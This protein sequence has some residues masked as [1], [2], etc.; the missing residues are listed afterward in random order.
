MP[1]ATTRRPSGDSRGL[2][3]WSAF[4]P[5]GGRRALAI[6]PDERARCLR[7]PCRRATRRARWRSRP[8][9]RRP[10]T[11]PTESTSGTGVPAT[12]QA[13]RRRTSPPKSCPRARTAA[14]RWPPASATRLRSAD[15]ASRSP[16]RRLRCSRGW[17]AGGSA[18]APPSTPGRNSASRNCPISSLAAMIVCTAPPL[19]GTRE[20]PGRASTIVPSSPQSPRAMDRRV[21]E[22]D[23][24]AALDRHP[25]ELAVGEEADRPA[26]RREER[27]ACRPRC[28]GSARRSDRPSRRR[29]RPGPVPPTT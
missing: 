24:C 20:R 23:R 14:R 13:R 4:G 29:S 17:A 28:R 27:P 5:G 8:R 11:T 6:E 16:A 9:R 2:R 12:R 18:P 21:G 10:R 26:V 15:G 25:L 22:H 19:A 7:R 3:I 1:L